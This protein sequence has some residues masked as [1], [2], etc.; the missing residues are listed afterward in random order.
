MTKA[1]LLG[2]VVGVLV[3]IGCWIINAVFKVTFG[4][5]TMI[6]W[7]SSIFLVATAGRE[8]TA[9]GW[10]I[11]GLAVLA[12]AFLFSLLGLGAAFIWRLLASKA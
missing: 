6:V 12:N 8:N 9:I 7:P 5:W 1:L 4:T 3:P 10:L 2:S 11:C